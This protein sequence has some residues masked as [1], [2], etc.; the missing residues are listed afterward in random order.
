MAYLHSQG[1]AHRD[2]KPENLFLSKDGELKIGDFGLCNAMRPGHPLLTSCGS[3]NYASPEV[4]S[5]ESYDGAASDVWSMGVVLYVLLDGCLPFSSSS[6][7]KLFEKIRSGKYREL[8]HISREASDLIRRM[9]DVN[10]ITRI[11]SK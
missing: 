9:L 11:T 2:I 7:S 6:Y 1:I 5:D 3:P 10:P 4:I 8:D